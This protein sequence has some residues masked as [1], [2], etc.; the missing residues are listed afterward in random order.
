MIQQWE[1]KVISSKGSI[2]ELQ[3][4]LN[5][6]GNKGWELVTYFNGRYIFKRPKTT[7]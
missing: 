6:E 4:W 2:D 5:K 3:S 1:Y 7:T